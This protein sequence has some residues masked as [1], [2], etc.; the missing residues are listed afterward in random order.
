MNDTL[1]K[2]LTKPPHASV[3]QVQTETTVSLPIFHNT[4]WVETRLFS[5]L[6]RY[7]LLGLFQCITTVSQKLLMCENN[8]RAAQKLS[9]YCK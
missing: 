1:G 7:F 8:C 3:T 9:T 2:R 5:S 6:D 4:T